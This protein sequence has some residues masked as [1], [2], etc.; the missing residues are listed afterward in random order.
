MGSRAPGPLHGLAYV[1]LALEL[2]PFF[3]QLPSTGSSIVTIRDG[4]VITDRIPSG[5]KRSMPKTGRIL[6]FLVLVGCGLRLGY[7]LYATSQPRY[8]WHDP[9]SYARKG[10]VIAGDGEGWRWTFDVVRHSSYD[11]RVYTLPPG[12]PVFLSLFAL[13]PGYPF[14]AQV[15]QVLLSTAVIALMFTLGQQIHS[16]R[17]GLIAA[18]IYAL[19]L[20]NIVAVWST[21]QEAIYVPLVLLATVVFLGCVR[22]DK[23][24]WRFAAAGTVF[25]LAALTRS[26]P[27]YVLPVMAVVLLLHKHR[28]ALPAAAGLVA[29]FLALTLPYSVALSR[30][31]GRATFIENH[32]SIF[33][34]ERYGG[35]EGD[36]PPALTQ[37]AKILLGGILASPAETSAQWLAATKSVLHVNG[38][39]LLQIYL[40]ATTR[41]GAWFAKLAAHF[42]ADLPF[43]GCLVLA[44]I[45]LVLCRRR[46]LAVYLLVWIDV[47][48]ALTMLSGFGG[49]RLRVPFEPHLIALAAV[50]LAGN[51]R[52]PGKALL[53]C[54]AAVSLLL[55]AIVLPQFPSRLR[56]RADYG[57]HWPL[58]APPKRS[59]MTARAGFNILPANGSVRFSVR[60]RN[61]GR[62]TVVHVTVDGEPA[63]QI[64]LSDREHRFE[65]PALRLELSYVEVEA[66]DARSG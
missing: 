7:L 65:L 31:L 9:D 13:Y 29:G 57:V 64:I 26:M 8:A 36:E 27:M 66:A 12:Y 43:A 22:D 19:W 59:P 39:L 11:H 34:V 49:P 41:A 30:D 15:A 44:P 48:F 24:W 35:V 5:M 45:G 10:R 58:K 42:A 3:E 40:G 2:V 47:N 52:E 23:P 54:G 63:E 4:R 61:P 51:Y 20:P 28:R 50:V 33:I 55:A 32:G 62:R 1:V 37:T 53:G 21:M 17:T 38:G 18:A 60:S 16:A 25:G 56:A 14:S 6:L 46:D